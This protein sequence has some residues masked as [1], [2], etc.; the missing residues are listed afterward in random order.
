[1]MT[2][3]RKNIALAPKELVRMEPLFP[4][5]PGPLRIEPEVPGMN[6]AEWAGPQKAFVEDLLFKH[7]ALLFRNFHIR[8]PDDFQA[9]VKATS[10]GN[11]LEYVDRTT[12]RPAVGDKI[13]LSTVYPSQET[14]HLHNEGT[15]WTQWPLKIYFCCLLAA[16]QGGETPVADTRR[17]Y[18]KIPPVIRDE[19]T[20]RNIMYVRN[21]GDGFGL[22]WQETFQ[23]KERGVVEQY[24]REHD[25][26]C[27]W[28]I[29]D[30]LR[31]RQ[32]RPAVRR[33]PKT[34]EMTW[35]NHGAFFHITS[36]EPSVREA[37]TQAFAEEDLPYNTYFG[38][39]SRIDPAMIEEIRRVYAGEKRMFPWQNGD[40]LLL[41]NMSFAHARQPYVGKRE[42]IV[43]MV[44]PQSSNEEHE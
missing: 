40:V 39:G 18:D 11:F 38:D 17:V 29:G 6:L 7:R 26:Q 28:K 43:A 2:A 34:G 33:H 5:Y 42:V 8:T 32:V 23:T 13:Y 36:L 25:I 4:D 20:Q 9:A 10:A 30:R 41:D 14:I 27:E 1:M 16:E 15:Y 37:L 31:T 44:E 35:F 21:Y 19:F 3:R 12:P 24:C 22:S